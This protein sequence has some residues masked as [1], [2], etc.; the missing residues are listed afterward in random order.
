M[1]NGMQGE[2]ICH[3]R[4]L[5]QGDRLSPMLFLLVMEV[6][7]GLFRKAD[8]WS[9]LQELPPRQIPFR[10]SMYADDMVLFLSPILKDLQLDNAIF[11]MFHGTSGLGCNVAKCQ[12]VPSAAMMPS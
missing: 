2:R 9:L 1:L 10:L 12:F 6:L 4:G 5:R 3:A 11:E 7:N 8:S